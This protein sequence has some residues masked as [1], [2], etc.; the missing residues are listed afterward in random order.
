MTHKITPI[1]YA[2][3]FLGSLLSIIYALGVVWRVEKKLD[4]AF[5]LFLTA[6]LS[7]TASEI[8]ALLQN[9][10]GLDFH[11]ISLALKILFVSFFLAGMLEMRR[12]LRE[13][14]GEIKK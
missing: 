5:K 4:I 11:F 9:Q 6:I 12:M 1:L 2:V 10:Q 8:C 7:F 14:D 3:L 13:M